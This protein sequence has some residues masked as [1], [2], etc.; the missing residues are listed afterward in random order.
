M[1][2]QLTY[3]RGGFHKVLDLGVWWKTQ[4][5]HAAAAGSQCPAP[6]AGPPRCVRNAA[7]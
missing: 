1:K 4:Y 5:A 6:L 7:A 3:S 2:G